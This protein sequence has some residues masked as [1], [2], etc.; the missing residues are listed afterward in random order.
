MVTRCG[1]VFCWPCLY[2]W[3]HTT[4]TTSQH[5]L[6]IIQQHHS[7]PVCKADLKEKIIPLYVGSR[8]RSISRSRSSNNKDITHAHVNY[9]DDHIEKHRAIPSR[10]SITIPCNS[11]ASSSSSSPSSRA[12]GLHRNQ[13]GVR[14]NTINGLYG[15][16]F[17]QHVNLGGSHHYNDGSIP[18]SSSFGIFPALLGLQLSS[19]NNGVPT[20]RPNR[21]GSYMPPNVLSTSND[22]QQQK[23]GFI[24]HWLFILL[25][26][27]AVACL[28]FF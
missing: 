9:E 10:P 11:S 13:R 27:F 12:E 26:T 17:N 19:Y 14:T 18:F 4:T 3:L 2:R 6:L 22:P 23:E 5:D 21:S 25:A 1:H 15:G 8:S 24:V 16:R 28:L 7:C 20:I